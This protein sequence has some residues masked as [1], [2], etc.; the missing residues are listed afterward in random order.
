MFKSS[1]IQDL[2]KSLNIQE[3]I[4]YRI[5]DLLLDSYAKFFKVIEHKSGDIIQIQ[6]K[7]YN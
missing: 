5:F 2:D 7:I 6:R 4:I 1:I 3:D